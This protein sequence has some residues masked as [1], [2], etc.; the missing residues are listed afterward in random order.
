MMMMVIIVMIIPVIVLKEL[1]DTVPD[2]TLQARFGIEYGSV[3]ALT[4][5]NNDD[6]DDDG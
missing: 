2:A 4:N 3:S 1:S 6:V 5:D